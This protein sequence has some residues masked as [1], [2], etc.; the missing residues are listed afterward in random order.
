MQPDSITSNCDGTPKYLNSQRNASRSA[1][2][3]MPPG[4][5]CYFLAFALVDCG[6]SGALLPPKQSAHIHLQ[7]RSVHSSAAICVPS[8]QHNMS[9]LT[10]PGGV[11]GASFIY[12][13]WNFNSEWETG[14]VLHKHTQKLQ[15]A[16]DIHS[17]SFSLLPPAKRC[18]GLDSK[19]CC[20]LVVH[21]LPPS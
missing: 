5:Y 21:L 13:K 2:I 19:C 8:R 16:R 17:S 6:P 18:F 20:C 15:A 10:P 7:S 3:W 9:R 12:F 14:D 11:H 1:H 4:P